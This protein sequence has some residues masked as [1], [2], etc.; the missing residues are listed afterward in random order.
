MTFFCPEAQAAVWRWR[1]AIAGGVLALLGFWLVSGPGFL[2]AV[3]GYAALGC[4]VMLGWLGVQRGRFRGADG[5]VGAVQVDE[6]QVS[7]FGPLTGGT[8][9]LRELESLTLDGRMFPAHW[10]LVQRGGDA[11]L[12]IP[13]NAAGAEALFDAF[14]TLPGL[15]TERML[16]TLKADPQSAVVIW[17]RDPTQSSHALLH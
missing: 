9:A 2:L 10:R 7:Y 15:R 8:V 4:G 17:Q 13:V 14:A 16:T 12:L 11:P 3:P 1:E 5:G 6:G